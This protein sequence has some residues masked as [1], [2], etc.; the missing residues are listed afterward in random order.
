MK[1][2]WPTQ[3]RKMAEAA[4]AAGT[5]P[6]WEAHTSENNGSGQKGFQN[7]ATSISLISEAKKTVLILKAMNT[8]HWECMIIDTSQE[9]KE[10]SVGTWSVM[11]TGLAT[12]GAPGSLEEPFL[13]CDVEQQ[14]AVC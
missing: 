1:V 5:R 9:K 14:W 13:L 3:P 8:G 2:R 6:C 11:C 7:L 10:I 4:A 12:P